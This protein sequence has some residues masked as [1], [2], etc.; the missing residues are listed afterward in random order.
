MYFPI[1]CNS[2]F[3]YTVVYPLL[4]FLGCSSVFV[5]YKFYVSS[6]SFPLR[7]SFLFLIHNSSFYSFSFC[8][9][10]DCL[11]FLLLLLGVNSIIKYS[12][13]SV[14]E[15]MFSMYEYMLQTR[16]GWVACV[17]ALRHCVRCT[18]GICFLRTWVTNTLCSSLPFKVVPFL[19]SFVFLLSISTIS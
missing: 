12:K 10:V 17:V 5:F 2:I 14:Y 1:F 3:L 7:H 9:W 8:I 11:V 18:Y 13:I 6:F 19:Q 16:F 15:Y 4:I